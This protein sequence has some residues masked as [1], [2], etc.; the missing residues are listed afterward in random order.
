M[1]TTV[2]VSYTYWTLNY[3]LGARYITWT[4]IFNPKT[5]LWHRYLPTPTV[6]MRKLEHRDVKKPAQVYTAKKEGGLDSNSGSLLQA[7]ALTFVLCSWKSVLT[8]TT[9][10]THGCISP[11]CRLWMIS[12]KHFTKSWYEITPWKTSQSNITFMVLLQIKYI[13]NL[14]DT[15]INRSIYTLW[16]GEGQEI[17]GKKK[18]LTHF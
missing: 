15:Q 5:T 8:H 9:K 13:I 12:V 16:V 10:P 6:R 14:K 18:D 11:R 17:K 7:Y 2:L 4:N 1:R 3:E